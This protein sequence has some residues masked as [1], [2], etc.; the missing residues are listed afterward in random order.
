[1]QV[2]SFQ[3]AH[4]ATSRSGLHSRRSSDVRHSTKRMPGLVLAAVKWVAQPVSRAAR[5][6]SL[7]MASSQI[8]ETM[9]GMKVY[10]L[11]CHVII[12]NRCVIKLVVIAV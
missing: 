3:T 6:K 2:V 1:M 4:P 9:L 10:L 5:A 12:E 7:V 8:K 11:N